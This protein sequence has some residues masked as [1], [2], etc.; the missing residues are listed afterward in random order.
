MHPYHS[1]TLG[2]HQM[3]NRM[4][5]EIRMFLSFQLDQSFIIS[6]FKICQPATISEN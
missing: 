1:R 6:P 5:P 3:S 2:S 4:L